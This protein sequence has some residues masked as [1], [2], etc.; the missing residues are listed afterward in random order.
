MRCVPAVLNSFLVK[1]RLP[2]SYSSRAKPI[3]VLALCAKLQDVETLHVGDGDLI[4]PVGIADDCRRGFVF[5]LTGQVAVDIE[6]DRL[7]VLPAADVERDLAGAQLHS[8][9]SRP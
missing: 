5:L 2:S 6:V 3:F 7:D 4:G 1:C 9:R 8:V